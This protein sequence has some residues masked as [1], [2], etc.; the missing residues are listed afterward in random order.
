MQLSIERT[1]GFAGMMLSA[2]VDLT[3]IDQAQA[4]ELRQLVEQADFFSLPE[5]ITS[6]EPSADRFQYKVTVTTDLM[7]HTVFVE[8]TTPPETLNALINKLM[9]FT[10]TQKK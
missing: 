8:N 10:R 3:S 7:E 6:D 4:D 1:G 9:A 5:K 2:T